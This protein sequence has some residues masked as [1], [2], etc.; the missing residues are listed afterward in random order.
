M[1]ILSSE[2][3]FV[4]TSASAKCAK[5]NAGNGFVVLDSYGYKTNKTVTDYQE[6]SECGWLNAATFHIV[7][8]NILGKDLKAE[9]KNEKSN[10]DPLKGL[11]KKR[12]GVV[13]DLSATQIE[14]WNY[15]IFKYESAPVLDSSGKPKVFKIEKKAKAAPE[16]NFEY[17]VETTI[18]FRKEG[19]PYW[20][21]IPNFQRSVQSK[22]YKYRLEIQEKTGRIVGG[23]WISKTA[24]FSM[25]VKQAPS[26]SGQVSPMETAMWALGPPS[27]SGQGSPMEMYLLRLKDL[28]LESKS[29]PSSVNYT[30][31]KTP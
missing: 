16:A 8:A 25:W 10:G 23:S 20:L 27:V 31:L 1:G 7:L 2:D 30:A 14:K 4:G 11:L 22:T 24:P 28:L 19:L 29:N 17:E 5:S 12:G 3:G 21:P 26:F 13:A 9:S 15:P 6:F 18:W